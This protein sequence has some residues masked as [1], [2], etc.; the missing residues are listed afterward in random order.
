MACIWLH[1][2]VINLIWNRVG[3]TPILKFIVWSKFDYQVFFIHHLSFDRYEMTIKNNT[4][5]HVKYTCIR[6]NKRVHSLVDHLLWPEK[7]W[8]LQKNNITQCI[9]LCCDQ[10]FYRPYETPNKNNFFLSLNQSF[11]LIKLFL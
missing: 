1:Q 9:F 3:Q 10:H 5:S 7:M 4:K 6:L 8:S 11:D 2:K